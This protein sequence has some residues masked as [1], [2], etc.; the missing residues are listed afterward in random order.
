MSDRLVRRSGAVPGRFADGPLPAAGGCAGSGLFISGLRRF[1]GPPG[2]AWKGRREKEVMT[3]DR[4]II[5]TIIVGITLLLFLALFAIVLRRGYMSRRHRRLDSA[6]AGARGLVGTFVATG[7]DEDLDLLRHRPGSIAW[8]AVEEQLFGA[9]GES[10][11]ERERVIDAFDRLGYTDHYVKRLRRG[12]KWAK[13]LSANHLGR[14]CSAR[15]VSHLI[16]ALGSRHRDVRNISV[17]SL[18]MM[19]SPRAVPHLLERLRDAAESREEVS[20]RI[21][22][23]SL[24]CYGE[25]IVPVM[26]R[27]LEN[28]SWRIRSAAV[29]ILAEVGTPLAVQTLIN[30][31]GDGERDVRAKA[32]RGLGNVYDR[33]AVPPL[34]LF[35]LT[36]DPFWV[37]RLQAVK[38]LGRIGDPL[39]TDYIARRLGDRK[40]QVRRA[41]A[42]ALGEIGPPAYPALLGTFLNSGDAFAREQ[43]A[44][45]MERSGA[46][47]VMIKSLL[48]RHYVDGLKSAGGRGARLPAESA[49]A[50]L[51]FGV[52]VRMAVLLAPYDPAGMVEVLGHLAAGEFSGDELA[53]AAGRAASLA[54]FHGARAAKTGG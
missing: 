25:E 52:L 19:R 5:Y 29:D 51:D 34:P 42:R 26:V 31:L 15:G 9:L 17:C 43:A 45:E 54:A 8:Q 44:E 49:P 2:T 50:L 32:A 12:S 23:S 10:G 39:S 18:G 48:D 46:A 24:A 28:P 6:R 4:I 35:R 14:L 41:A 16:E 3:V 7:S 33:A 20:I 40:W 11:P 1:E 30:S 37:V 47:R 13:A 36:T 21:I 53:L 27:E 22:K 38:A